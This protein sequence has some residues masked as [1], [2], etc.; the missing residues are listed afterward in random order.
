MLFSNDIAA[1]CCDS[2]SEFLGLPARILCNP[3]E[4]I[5]VKLYVLWINGIFS[6]IHSLR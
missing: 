2:T 6:P 1:S 4:V 5:V 3:Q